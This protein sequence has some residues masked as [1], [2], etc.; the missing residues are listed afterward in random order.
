M[1]TIGEYINYAF[2]EFLAKTRMKYET[3]TPS[4][5]CKQN[6]KVILQDNKTTIKNVSNML[7]SQK[8]N[9]NIWAMAI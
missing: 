8:F 6:D 7:H 2:K 3:N 9:F 5:Y 1:T 4:H